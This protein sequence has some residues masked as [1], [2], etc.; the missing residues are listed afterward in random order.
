M[1]IGQ[2]LQ[3][4]L[5]RLWIV[6][7]TLA[8]AL[9]VAV[10]VLVFVPPRF[11]AIAS[12][13]IDPGNLDPLS[14]GSASSSFIQL[15]QGNLISLVESERVALA[16][17]KQLNLA[18]D[19]AA[20]AQF[21]AS[22][23]FGRLP[24]ENY[25]AD[26]LLKSI[27][28][29]FTLGANVLTIKVKSSSALRSSLV[30][31][32]FMNATIDAAVEMKA[33][34][35]DQTVRW[36]GPQIESLR[37][38]LAT[39]RQ[40]LINFQKQG[41]LLA[42]QTSGDSENSKLMAV[43]QDLSAAKAN[44]TALQSRLASPSIDLAMDPSDPDLQLLSA[45]KTRASTAEADVEQLKST[46][47]AANPKVASAAAQVKAVNQ[48][49]DEAVRKMRD[50]LRERI[51]ATKAQIATIEQTRAKALHEMIDVQAQRDTL[52]ELQ[53]NVDVRQAQLEAQEKALAQARL[54]SKLNFSSLTILDKAVPPAD[55]AFPKPII[56]LPVSIIGGLALG[57]I[58]GLL[59][60]ALDRRIRFSEDLTFATSVK[61]LGSVPVRRS[62][63]QPRTLRL[64]KAAG[65]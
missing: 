57:L 24:I 56:V 55:P 47:G 53:R 49:V 12:A 2:I 39:A 34:S 17:V 28:A 5:R 20:Q 61:V 10:A 16:V 65:A 9:G 26:D 19:P 38:E 32:A 15:M 8:A 41:A 30:A 40:A 22:G 4:L 33:A 62:R 14:G 37:A 18:A 63:A 54:Q 23:S 13:S 51:D 7:M 50:H 1:T 44:L 60:E 6:F 29:K 58:L 11:D 35:A 45:L 21:R 42:P 36:F 46:L 48:Q 3:I 64:P 25:L 59:A 27:D 52:A 43:T 31:N